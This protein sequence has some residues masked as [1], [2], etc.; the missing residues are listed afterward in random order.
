MSFLE[1]SVTSVH[2]TPPLTFLLG[3]FFHIYSLFQAF[4]LMQAIFCFFLQDP[5]EVEAGRKGGITKFTSTVQAI[6]HDNTISARGFVLKLGGDVLGLSGT[7]I[8]F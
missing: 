1:S 7:D 5:A 8:F 3:F 4:A 2:H 6:D